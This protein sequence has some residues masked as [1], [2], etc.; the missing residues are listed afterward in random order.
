MSQPLTSS[1]WGMNALMIVQWLHYIVWWKENNNYITKKHFYIHMYIAWKDKYI[2]IWQNFIQTLLYFAL[3]KIQTFPR[4]KHFSY[5]QTK[6]HNKEIKK[7]CHSNVYLW[8]LWQTLISWSELTF[9]LHQPLH[10]C[11]TFYKD[12]YEKHKFQ[13]RGFYSHHLNSPQKEFLILN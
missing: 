4:M 3:K 2:F 12:K 5:K 6:G 7:I 9:F 8:E 1:I 11:N 13:D 10:D